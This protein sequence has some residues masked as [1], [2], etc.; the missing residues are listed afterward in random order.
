MSLTLRSPLVIRVMR[1]VFVLLLVLVTVLSLIPNPDAVPG[2]NAFSRWV[3]QLLFGDP[4]HGDKVSHF[5]AYGVIG[6][7]GILA[8][9][10][11]FGRIWTLPVLLVAFS[12]LIEIC[13]G[14]TAARQPDLAD[15]VANAGGVSAGMLAAAGLVL[16]FGGSPQRTS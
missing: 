10:K 1:A 5:I 9:L 12:G 7:A 14:L 4:L 3:A 6:G 13:Q 15:M 11:P 16:L 8:A 2:A